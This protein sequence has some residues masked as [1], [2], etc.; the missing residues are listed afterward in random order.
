[1]IR[2]RLTNAVEKKLGRDVNLDFMRETGFK[3]LVF[4]EEKT[5]LDILMPEEDFDYKSVVDIL[6]TFSV[7]P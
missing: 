5:G 2:F 4:I 1:M 3:K 6:G 7:F